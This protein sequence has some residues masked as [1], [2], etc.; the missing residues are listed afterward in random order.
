MEAQMAHA[1]GISLLG[2][3][4]NLTEHEWEPGPSGTTGMTMKMISAPNFTPG[5]TVLL[6]RVARGG[7]FP[8]HAHD[9]LHVFY[10]LDGT[11]SFTLGREKVDGGAGTVIRVPSRVPH[12]Y[13]NSGHGDLVLLVINS[14]A[15]GEQPGTA[16]GA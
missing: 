3:Q 13:I 10:V 9:Y 11:A 1:S 12:G 15:S 14:Y 8:I 16:S 5:V 4:D 7:A 6:S 2:L